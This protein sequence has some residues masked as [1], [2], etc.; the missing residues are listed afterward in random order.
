MGV[1]S[2]RARG[3]SDRLSRAPL[4]GPSRE[5][6]LA[7]RDAPEPGAQAAAVRAMMRRIEPRE[8]GARRAGQREARLMASA[9]MTGPCHDPRSAGRRTQP[10]ALFAR[11]L[12]GATP[13][14]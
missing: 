12:P 4:R 9:L 6:Q 10:G 11:A 2:R 1:G 7:A 14:T 5:G 8:A 13:L 3:A